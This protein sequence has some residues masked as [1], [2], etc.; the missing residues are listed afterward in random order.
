MS[1][2]IK[3][4]ILYLSFVSLIVTLAVTCFSQKVELESK[5]Y[6]TKE[7]RFQDQLDATANANNLSVSIDHQVIDNTIQISIPKELISSNFK[8]EMN[9]IRPSDSS[10]DKKINL[11][12]D[13]AGMCFINTAQFVKG[14][15]KMQIFITSNSKNYYKESIINFH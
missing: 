4:A 2:G 6:Y 10:L 14:V 9:L 8:G 11:A 1:W 3:I 13:T 7:L 5:D 12:P 15:Y